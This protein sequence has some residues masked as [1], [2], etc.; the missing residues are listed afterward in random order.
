MS[1]SWTHTAFAQQVR[2]GEGA[3]ARLRPLLKDAGSRRALVLTSPSAK[4]PAVIE[5]LGRAV[6]GT[7]EDTAPHLPVPVVRAAVGRAR[8]EAIDTIVSIGGGSVIELGKAIAFFLEQEAG[9]PGASFADRPGFVHV[10]IPTTFAGA[11]G[12]THFSMTDPAARHKQSASSPT[13]V[14]RWVVYDPLLVASTPIGVLAASAA[15]ALGHAIAAVLTPTSAEAEALGTAA[16]GRLYGGVGMLGDATARAA[17]LEGAALAARAAANAAPSLVDALAVL[18]GGRCGLPH[19][20]STAL[21]LPPVLR[22]NREAIGSRVEQAARTIGVEDL[23]GALAELRVEL[24]LPSGLA[25]LGVT[26]DDIGAVARLSQQTAAW[27]SNP[28]PLGESDVVA[29]LEAAW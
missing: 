28:R 18:L 12:S 21:L 5:G 1:A 22:F 19:G 6:V 15:T 2:F 14:P 25:S 13:I 7:F 20:V 8:A 24:G 3:S 29:M 17:T 9:T 16:L 4:A 10:A 11:E 27:R 26:D 23:P